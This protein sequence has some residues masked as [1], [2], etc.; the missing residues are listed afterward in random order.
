MGFPNARSRRALG[1]IISKLSNEN[2]KCIF[3]SVYSR[4]NFQM[5][6]PSA[7]LERAFG[8]PMKYLLKLYFLFSLALTLQVLN[9]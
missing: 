1:E 4:S 8:K 9:F 6:P 5:I 7:R 3:L 2:E